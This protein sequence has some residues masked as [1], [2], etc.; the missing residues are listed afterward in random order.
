MDKKLETSHSTSLV[1]L[2]DSSGFSVTSLKDEKSSPNSESITAENSNSIVNNQNCSNVSLVSLFGEQIVSMDIDGTKRLCLAQISHT[3]LKDFSYNEIHNRRVALGITCIQCTP[4]QLE[5][6]RRSGAMPISSRRCGMITYR[7]AERLCKSFLCESYPPPIPEN[8][9]F[10]VYHACSYG[11]NGTFHP[12]RYNS[13]RAKCIRCDHCSVFFSPNKFIFHSHMEV[14]AKF[15]PPD[16]ANFNSWRRHIFLSSDHSSDEQ[17][18]HAWEDVKAMFNG[19]TRKRSSTTQTSEFLEP[20]LKQQI[21][22]K[23]VNQ[24]TAKP[25]FSPISADSLPKK[26]TPSFAANFGNL[27]SF[28]NSKLKPFQVPPASTIAYSGVTSNVNSNSISKFSTI[29]NQFESMFKQSNFT[30]SSVANQSS[31]TVSDF[32]LPPGCYNPMATAAALLG[33]AALMVPWLTQNP[34]SVSG[35]PMLPGIVPSS[36][37]SPDLKTFLGSAG[38]TGSS[39]SPGKAVESFSKPASFVMGD[40]SGFKSGVAESM[41]KDETSPPPTAGMST[42]AALIN[43]FAPNSMFGV[44]GLPPLPFTSIGDHYSSTDPKASIKD[45]NIKPQDVKS[46]PGNNEMKKI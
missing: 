15:N 31:T 2:E 19:G 40:C 29:S 37:N 33:P 43:S 5:V 6:L 13:S 45:V 21:L 46:E 24:R 7:E 32:L 3:L 39:S 26:N 23:N 41:K 20:I 28:S 17:I 25:P 1:N 42:Q 27:A 35:F 12:N 4:V 16:A 34:G 14:G 44:S 10:R 38:Y 22:S 11:C 36:V 30:P 9:Q 8:F 18:N